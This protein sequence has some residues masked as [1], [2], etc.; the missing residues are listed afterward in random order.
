M[1]SFYQLLNH[2]FGTIMRSTLL[3]SLG[4]FITPFILMKLRMEQLGAKYQT[5]ETVFDTSGSAI[6]CAAYM[7]AFVLL[8]LRSIYSGYRG[9]KSIY[10]LLALP[11]PRDMIYWSK[12]AAFFIG[13]F[14]LWASLMLSVIINYGSWEAN[15][16]ASVMVME[17]SAQLP[18]HNGLF[19]AVLRSAFLSIVFPLSAKGLLAT[20]STMVAMI[21][22]VFY[23]VL[24]ERS[25]RKWGVVL[26][27]GGWIFLMRGTVVRLN[28]SSNLDQASMLTMNSIILLLFASLYMWHSVRLYRAGTIAE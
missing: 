1:K 5:F 19:L 21:T 11:V 12:L 22:F 9:S 26:L 27:V 4:M 8:M 20:V 16:E 2:E 13:L 28:I 15:V 7:I 10:T 17:A 25:R 6:A 18:M 24:C 14:M 3:L 23:A